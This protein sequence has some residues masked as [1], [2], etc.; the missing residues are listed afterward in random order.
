MQLKPRLNKTNNPVVISDE[1]ILLSGGSG[2]QH[3]DH[4]NVKHSTLEI[5]SGPNKTGSRVMAYILTNPEAT[6]WRT[7]VQ[8]YA[9]AQL[10]YVTYE[11]YGD[12]VEA[13]DINALQDAIRS[14]SVSS[15]T[16]VFTQIAPSA[17]WVITHDLQ[18]RPSVTVVDSAGTA[19]IGDILYRSDSEI[20]ARFQSPF[21]GCAYLN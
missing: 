4:D 13:E 10:V 16:F 18:K 15:G 8:V 20:E 11:T 9:S 5:W 1:I 17:T 12:Q 19:V 6:P 2:A 3:L 7:H 14:L 21:A